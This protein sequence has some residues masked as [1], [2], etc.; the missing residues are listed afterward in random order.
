MVPADVALVQ[1]IN[2]TATAYIQNA[3]AYITYREHTRISAPSLGRTQ[4]I[5][6]AVAVRQADDLAV[7][8]DLPQGAVRVG[9]AFPIIPYFDPLGQ[10]FN[11][12][13]HAN[14]KNVDI[15]LHRLPVGL[16][17]VPAPDPSVNVF[18]PYASFWEPTYLPDSSPDRLHMRITPTS[19]YGGD[20]YVYEV[21]VDPQTQL[22]SRIELRSLRDASDIIIDYH[23]VEN[24]WVI[25]HATYTAPQHFGPMNFTIVTDTSYDDIAF[26]ATAPDP[27]LAGTPAPT[28]TPQ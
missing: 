24:H 19:T 28:P 25:S 27:R 26:P 21:A 6:R 7:M 1:L 3:P 13:W 16:W 12:G 9:Q 11:F 22:P 5:N 10:G 18:V 23:V 4:E 17:P 8:Q 20:I 2:R 15:E 14:L